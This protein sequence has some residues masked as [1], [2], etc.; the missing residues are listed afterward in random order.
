[1][2]DGREF[3]DRN[4]YVS[5]LNEIMRKLEKDGCDRVRCMQ[6]Q[7]LLEFYHLSLIKKKK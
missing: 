7:A 1:M 3:D 5:N 4:W 6:G 2:E